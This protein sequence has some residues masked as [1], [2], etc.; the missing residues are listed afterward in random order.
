MFA[1][2]D[3]KL[4]TKYERAHEVVSHCPVVVVPDKLV[5]VMEY[6]T[7]AAIGTTTSRPVGHPN[8]VQYSSSEHPPERQMAPARII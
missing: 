3:V 1:R 7:V 4:L 8:N 6:G 5:T 2:V